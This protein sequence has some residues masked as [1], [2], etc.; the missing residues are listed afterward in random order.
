MSSLP[1]DLGHVCAGKN[2]GNELNESQDD[3][4]DSVRHHHGHD[5]ILKVVLEQ[6]QT[7]VDENLVY[8]LIL[9]F[10]EDP[11]SAT[12]TRYVATRV[13][14]GEVLADGS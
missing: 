10:L 1:C 9:T 8:D 5:I 2:N 14:N 3:P 4:D 11:V 12:G 6:G 7:S 13:R